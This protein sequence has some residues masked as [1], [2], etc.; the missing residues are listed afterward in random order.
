MGQR[1][2]PPP[3]PSRLVP[4]P[5]L[6]AVGQPETTTGHRAADEDPETDEDGLTPF[7]RARATWNAPVIA[8]APPEH[9]T[10]R[11]VPVPLDDL[12]ETTD[13]DQP[14]S[15]TLKLAPPPVDHDPTDTPPRAH[16]T[17]PAAAAK[18]GR[19]ASSRPRA[20]ATAR[21]GAAERPHR[22][23]RHCRTQRPHRGWRHGGQG[24]TCC[25]RRG[26]LRRGERRVGGTGL[27]RRELDRRPERGPAAAASLTARGPATVGRAA[28]RRR[29]HADPARLGR[30][31]R[32][33]QNPQTSQPTDH[34]QPWGPD[35][36]SDDATQVQPAWTT[37]PDQD[38]QPGPRSQTRTSRRWG[39]QQTN[40]SDGWARNSPAKTPAKPRAGPHSRTATAAAT[41]ARSS[42]E[43]SRPGGGT[44]RAA[45][46]GRA[47]GRRAGP[48]PSGMGSPGRR[49]ADGWRAQA[50]R[51][52]A[53]AGRRAATSVPS[54]GLGSS[55]AW[56][57]ERAGPG[58]GSSAGR[59]DAG[60]GSS[61]ERQGEQGQGWGAQQSGVQGD[62]KWAAR[63]WGWLGAGWWLGA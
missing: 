23:R 27:V 58:V 25:G 45:G 35:E 50:G 24:R 39:A 44:S 62:G 63:G 1:R 11:E 20:P 43:R 55:A 32:D 40:R 48:R 37:Q 10:Q 61:A 8:P 16:P 33:E 38:H 54:A 17:Q 51:G 34:T 4:A 13:Q 30:A 22:S 6:S 60:L 9:W 59:P 49:R 52:P 18:A 57:G 47:A 3:Q 14:K 29:A 28:R 46:L 5:H 56:R 36:A 19:E 53:R 41:R 21:S 31:A 12:A 42:G 26:H 2:A 15:W 7:E